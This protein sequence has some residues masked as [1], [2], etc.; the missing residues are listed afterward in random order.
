MAIILHIEN[1]K[2]RVYRVYVAV[3]KYFLDGLCQDKV[4]LLW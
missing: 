4:C 3:Y 1:T 2:E